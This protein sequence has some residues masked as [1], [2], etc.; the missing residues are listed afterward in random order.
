MVPPLNDDSMKRKAPKPAKRAVTAIMKGLLK[1]I[2]RKG[3]AVEDQ[4]GVEAGDS[5]PI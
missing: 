1:G 4:F 5:V 2:N 3:F